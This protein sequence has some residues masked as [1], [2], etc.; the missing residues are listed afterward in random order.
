[1]IYSVL[2]FYDLS[3][4]KLIYYDSLLAFCSAHIAFLWHYGFTSGPPWQVEEERESMNTTQ[5]LKAARETEG[6]ALL[7]QTVAPPL[8]G[9]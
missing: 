8:E 7:G 1:M 5:A 9:P 6:Q 2:L 3:I 4:F